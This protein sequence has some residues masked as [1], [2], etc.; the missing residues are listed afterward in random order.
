MLDTLRKNVRRLSWTLWLV[1]LAFVALYVPDLVSGGATNVIARVDGDPIMADEF[2]QALGEQVNYY[3][4]LN[5]GDMTPELMQQLQLD[6]VVL[7]QLIRRRLILAAA[8]DQGFAVA[9]QEIKD[10]IMEY[11]VFR[12][13]DNRWVGD[14]EYAVILR[15]NGLQPIDF[16]ASVIDDLMVERLTGLITEGVDVSD[17]EL[18]ELY[19]RQNERVRFD[20][21]QIRPTAFELEVR[22]SITDAD[23]QAHYDAETESYRLPEQRRVSYAVLDTETLRDGIQIDED[24]LRAEYDGRVADFTIE[25]QVKARQILIRV[26]PNSDDV[27]RAEARDRARGALERAQAGEDFAALAEEL[28]DDPSATAGGDLGWVTRGRQVEGFDEPVFALEPGELSDLVETSFGFHV[29][30]V[31]EK[32][33]ELVQP[34][35]EVRGQLEQQLAWDLAEEDAAALSER[36]RRRILSGESLEEILADQDMVLEQS[37]LFSASAG[38]GEFTSSE[39]TNRAFALG[40]GRTAEPVRVR[41]GYLVFR[42]DE[43]AAPHT[44]ALADVEDGVRADV[45]RLRSVDR[46]AEVAADYAARLADG[47]DLAVIAEEASTVVESTELITRDDFV[48]VLGRSPELLQVAFGLDSM[49]VGGPIEV[50]DRF[51]VLRVAEHVQPDW[52]LFA[53][54]KPALRDQ[55]LAERR[56]RLFEAFVEALRERYTVRVYDDVME[57]VLG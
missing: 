41:R 44:P 3:R 6:R 28:S 16:E 40:E 10:R 24:T 56:N 54:Q 1:I 25:E 18:Q 12:G 31:E 9:P 36:L 5:Q 21:V 45:M 8:R 26:P 15:R 50:N 27:A 49:Q 35:E 33:A 57:R 48:P 53:D 52:S 7:E 11:P 30:S 19:Q 22:D 37:P 4:Q 17:R 20:F 34:F 29:V 32:R 43:I 13:A 55:D 2:Q 38:F 39:F 46:A 51:I 23:L 42:V 47:A 14:Q